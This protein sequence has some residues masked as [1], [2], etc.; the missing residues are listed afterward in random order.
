[1]EISEETRQTRLKGSELRSRGTHGQSSA[2]GTGERVTKVE[3]QE[4]VDQVREILFGAQREEYDRK[5]SRL[6][7]LLVE[8]T[9]DLSND[10]TK[11]LGALRDEYDKRFAR[12]EE[13]LVKNISDLSNDTTK[14]LGAL[15]DEH[16]KRFARLEELLAKSMSDLSNDMQKLSHDK[17]DKAA[18][19]KLLEKILKISHDLNVAM[20][21]HSG[22]E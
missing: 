17:V 12:L 8:R 14:K 11:K 19:S 18:V 13:L 7:E 10:T 22:D 1:V 9:S 3:E 21:E 15:R 2:Q 4:R 5:F 16:D 6:E 20:S